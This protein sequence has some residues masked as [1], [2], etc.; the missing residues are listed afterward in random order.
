MTDL[1][2]NLTPEQVTEEVKK[3]EEEESKDTSL[4]KVTSLAKEED[5][6]PEVPRLTKEQMKDMALKDYI[7]GMAQ[8]QVGFKKLSSRGVRRL[9]IAALQ[10]PTEGMKVHFQSNEEKAMFGVVQRV[11]NSKFSLIL[12]SIEEESLKLKASKEQANNEEK[13]NVNG[14][15]ESTNNTN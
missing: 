14:S 2:T 4:T 5:K 11:L 10:L 8:L 13:A 12:H 6:N 1:Q 15:N 9:F 7:N 3:L